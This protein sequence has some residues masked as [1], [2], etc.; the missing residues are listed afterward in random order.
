MGLWITLASLI[1]HLCLKS[2]DWNTESALHLFWDFKR[3]KFQGMPSAIFRPSSGL[4]GPPLSNTEIRRSSS[5][6]ARSCVF[7]LSQSP[8]RES[9]A[10][11]QI[12]ILGTSRFPY[13]CG[14]AVASHVVLLSAATS[15]LLGD[16]FGAS[17]QFAPHVALTLYSLH[18]YAYPSSLVAL[19][20][21]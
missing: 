18:M 9:R 2:R 11:V 13:V 5:L 12:Q 4:I 19:C 21:S 3:F 15:P 14:R 16:P 1:D 10:T 7:L 20:L 8:R 6:H 17:L